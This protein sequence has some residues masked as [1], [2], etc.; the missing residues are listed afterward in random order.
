M[1]RAIRT[2]LMTMVWMAGTCVVRAQIIDPTTG[3]MVD[4]TTDPSDFAAVA[5]GQP[6]N[7]GMELSAQA[8]EQAQATIASMQAQAAGNDALMA[9]NDQDDSAPVAAVPVVPKT[10]KPAMTPNGGTFQGSLQVTIADSDPEAA[11][12]YTT[13]GKKPTTSSAQFLAPITVTTKEKIRAMAV[14]PGDRAS[15]V[16][17]KSFKVG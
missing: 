10:P 2:A 6:G 8:V 9:A 7:I 5:G 15:G 12:F 1:R 16:V 17:T 13:D 14:V 11:I 4:A 3:V